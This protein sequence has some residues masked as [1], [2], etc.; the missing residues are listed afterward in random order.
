MGL[1]FEKEEDPGETRSHLA[2]C[3]D[4]IILL[5]AN[6]KARSDSSLF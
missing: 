3:S 2:K 1:T 5:R 6:Y 4:E